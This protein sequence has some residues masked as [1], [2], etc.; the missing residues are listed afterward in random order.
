MPVSDAAPADTSA[1]D[2]P[3]DAERTSR[4]VPGEPGIWILLFGDMAIFAVLFGVYLHQRGK[5]K[6]L[7]EHSQDLLNRNFGA[8]NTLVLLTSSLL[9]FMAV[10]A[11]RHDKWRHL[12]SRLTLAGAGVGVCFVFIKAAEYREKISAGLTP[13]TNDFFMYYFVLTGL[14]LGHVIIGLIVLVLLSRLAAR[15]TT[16]STQ[17]AF[18]EGGACF[19]HMVDLLWIIIFPLVFLVR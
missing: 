8:L 16:T 7:F 17:M 1:G 15:R 14:H 11:L 2:P 10:R 12:A 5:N 9:V 19:W 13:S 18:F 4:H 3:L 6:E